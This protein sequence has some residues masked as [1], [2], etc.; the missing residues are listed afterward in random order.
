MNPFEIP[1][2]GPLSGVKVIISGLTVAGPFAASMMADFGADVIYVESPHAMDQFRVNDT[3]GFLN[4]ERRNQR[5]IVLDLTKPEGKEVFLK[6]V[7][8]A[9]IFIEN[10]KAGAW[11][12]RGLT[13][14]VLWETNARLV[15][16][17]VTGFGLTGDPD[18]LKRGSYD[19]I[20]QAFS[21]Y[22]NINGEPEP[23][24]P[25][26]ASAF[27]GDYVTAMLASWSCL[28]AYI[29]ALKTGKGE[30][31]DC[32]QYEALLM[33]QGSF[34][35]DWFT[36]QVERKRAGAKNPMFSGSKPFRCKDGY[37]YTFILGFGAMKKALPLFGLEFG[38]E[39]FPADQ[40][41]P[42]KGT[43]GGDLLDE[44]MDAYCADK[45]VEEVER[46]F[47]QN[48]IVC[49][50]I[51]T[52]QQ[53]EDH[54]HYTARGSLMEWDAFEGGKVKGPAI[55]PRLK[56]NP[57][58]VWRKAPHYGQDNE[59]V[60]TELGYSEEQIKDLYSKEVLKQDP[61]Y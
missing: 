49:S 51:M 4:K 33:V 40:Y 27:M 2:F 58:K 10:S 9:D 60:L 3:K 11:D 17:H 46:V 56:N 50:T 44:K 12:A 32:A 23:G 26:P 34:P 47:N 13:D 36:Y 6:L 7:K 15:I 30:S 29:K 45:T 21:G 39:Y 57:G 8:D 20:G 52:Y 35:S 5:A 19:A 24:L 59:Q 38:S 18:Y 48:G 55:T 37:V 42:Y 54:P 14:E 61:N 41:G 43:P 16:A 53:M 25:A 31:I 1:E 22:M 28:A